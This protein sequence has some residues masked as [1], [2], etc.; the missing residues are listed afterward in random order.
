MTWILSTHRDAPS[1]PF[2]IAASVLVAV[3]AGMW[4]LLRLFG[5]RFRTARRVI[6]VVSSFGA[7]AMAL[8]WARSVDHIDRAS[9]RHKNVKCKISSVHGR[10]ELDL[11]DGIS[12]RGPDHVARSA[13]SLPPDWNIRFEF[14][15]VGFRWFVLPHWSLMFLLTIPSLS[16]LDTLLRPGRRRNSDSGVCAVCG[17]DLRATPDQC[18]ECGR[19][20]ANAKLPPDPA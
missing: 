11:Y 7:V 19:R 2:T 17:Y 3:A 20:V 14:R 6:T 18:P 15:C 10:I 12:G 5:N 16:K 8:L 4:F 9:I 13:D 1:I